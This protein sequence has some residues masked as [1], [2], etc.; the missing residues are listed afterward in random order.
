[1]NTYYTKCGRTFEKS[2][3]A[4]TTGYHIAEENGVIADQECADCPFPIDVKDGWGDTATHKRW[5]CRAGS[6]P[7]NHENAYQGSADD[8]CT[9]QVISLDHDF[10]EAV[11]AYAQKH[12]DLG[13]NY[14]Q[15]RAD[16]RRV[17]SVSCSQN[18]KGMEAKQELIDKFFPGEFI[19]DPEDFQDPKE[20]EQGFT[21]ETCYHAV[22]GG[23]ICIAGEIEKRI[24][25]IDPACDSYIRTVADEEFP[26][27]ADLVEDL[28]E[29]DGE[30]DREDMLYDDD[31]EPDLFEEPIDSSATGNESQGATCKC[32]WC[33]L[34]L[35]VPL[36]IAA[37]TDADLEAYAMEH[38]TC[39][40][41]QVWQEETRQR[42]ERENLE[43]SI[44]DQLLSIS[45]MSGIEESFAAIKTLCLKVYD[46]EIDSFT[47]KP[48]FSTK[49]T[50]K[51]KDG[52]I[53]M[54][55]TDTLKQMRQV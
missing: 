54:E 18:K 6:E 27:I 14:T 39:E 33:G 10:C 9:L 51:R 40:D 38:C 22:A 24:R 50:V 7:P 36:D 23:R 43:K 4:D 12:P 52:S 41:A 42:T 28:D 19:A 45:E 2:T 21:C 5:E 29:D 35:P 53:V 8:K 47:F 44:D 30:D 55:R 31:G 49:I 37:D 34:Y 1:M 15:D 48:D 20:E 17:V 46:Y 32:P 13:A 26:L 3:K 16:C 25:P 11:I